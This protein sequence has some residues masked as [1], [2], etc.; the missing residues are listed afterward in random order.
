[1]LPDFV[2]G[3]PELE[4]GKEFGFLVLPLGMGLVG[5]RRVFLRPVARVL[6][7]QGGSD[8]QHFAQATVLARGEDHAA[9]LRV[10]RQLRQLAAK[11]R[12]L[13]LFKSR[14]SGL[15]SHLPR[16]AGEAGRGCGQSPQLRQELVAVGDHARRRRFE[17]REV[18]DVAQVQRLH[19]QDHAGQAGAQDLGLGI[20]RAL[21]E[22][23]LVVE[24]EANARRDAAAAPG[25]LAGRRARNRLD[26]QSFNL[27][28]MRVAL[29]PGQARVDHVADAGHGQR[30]LG[31]IGRQ[32][33][34][35]ALVRGKDA[36]LLDRGLAREQ[37]QY[38]KPGRE[39]AK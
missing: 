27:A 9:D 19:A 31:H 15:I 13:P 30:S 22:I 10:E 1:M 20:G 5:R 14:V 37:R 12:Q 6:A 23:L 16:S 28:A 8:D 3:G 35:L 18:L 4:V 33:H 25:A 21:V 38:L 32:H 26:L 29:D 39:F 2:A 11:R 36:A 24:P 7:A 17:E 34:A